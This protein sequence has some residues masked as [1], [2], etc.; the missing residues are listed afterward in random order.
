[1]DNGPRLTPLP[2]ELWDDT[3]RDALAPLL[4]AQRANPHDAGNVLATLVRHP[5]LAHAYLEF[6]AHLLVRS[7][8][9]ARVREVAL[10]R[11]V[12]H[13]RSDYLWDHHVPIAQRA[14]LDIEE[15]EAIRRGEPADDLDRLV[16][17]TVDELDAESTLSDATWSALRDRFDERQILDL[18]FSVGCYQLLAVAVNTLG[19][20]PEEH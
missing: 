10:L 14:G 7:T 9:S 13:R 4:P 18:I 12:Q 15:I 19:I 1:V 2:E 17:A 5:A 3:A 6:N 20:E 8:L 16:V 11:A